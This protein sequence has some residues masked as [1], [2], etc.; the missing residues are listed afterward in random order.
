[1]GLRFRLESGGWIIRYFVFNQ[2]QWCSPGQLLHL[3][4]NPLFKLLIFCFQVADAKKPPAFF[5]IYGKYSLEML[6]KRRL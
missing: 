6:V 4:H 5:Q 1:M 2:K 3:A